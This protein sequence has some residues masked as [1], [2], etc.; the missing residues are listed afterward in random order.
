MMRNIHETSVYYGR[1]FD[2][3][4]NSMVEL[5]CCICVKTSEVNETSVRITTHET[6]VNAKRRL[7]SGI[8]RNFEYHVD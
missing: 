4:N 8:F 1:L 7:R 3:F 2:A 5:Q 6:E